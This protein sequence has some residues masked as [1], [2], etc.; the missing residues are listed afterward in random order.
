MLQETVVGKTRISNY[1][2][3]F[4]INIIIIFKN[5]ENVF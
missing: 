1:N 2:Y 3:Y 4:Y 5:N